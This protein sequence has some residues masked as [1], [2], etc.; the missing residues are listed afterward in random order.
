MTKQSDIIDDP[1]YIPVLD[2]GFAGLVNHLGGDEAITRAARVSYG[3]GTKKVSEERALIRYLMRHQ[4]CYHPDMEVLTVHGWKKWRECSEIETFLVPN[5]QTRTYVRETLKVVS[6]DSSEDLYVFENERMSYKVTANHKMWFKSKYQTEFK[7]IPAN[8]KPNWG[9]FDP[10][11]G[12]READDVH[13][14]G[15]DHFKFIGF[16]LGDGCHAS[17]N[18]ITFHLKKGRKIAYLTQLLQCLEIDYSSVPS[19]THSDGL[20]FNV[21]TPHFLKDWIDTTRRSNE[22]EFPLTRLHQLSVN[23]V[24]GLFDGLV[25]SDGNLA[26]DRAQLRFS[27]QSKKLI[28]LF[29]ALS[30]RIGF[31]A[32]E[33]K[34]QEGGYR[35]TAYTEGRTSLE[36]R[37][38]YHSRESYVGKVY[39]TTTSTGLLAVR[40]GPDKFGFICGNSSPFEMVEFTFHLKMPI[41]VARQHLRHRMSSTNEYSGRY[42][43]M[44]DEFYVPDLEQIAAQSSDNKQGRAGIID[45]LSKTGVQWLIR[46]VHDTAY[47]VYRLLLGE[48][49]VDY[50]D[51]YDDED[52]LLSQEFPG[53]AREIARTVLPVSN[54]TEMYWKIDL[55]NLFKFLRLR[56]DSH[57]QYEIRVLAEAIYQ[58]IQP[59]APLA[60]EAFEDYMRRGVAFSRMDMDVLRRYIDLPALNKDI[61]DLGGEL[62]FGKNY[63]LGKREV[64]DLLAHLRG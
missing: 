33:I 42:S 55:S 41:F 14:D 56:M 53:I 61:D 17:T 59:L 12:Y 38:Q 35:A 64:I 39:C 63:G 36:S 26:C 58:L 10:L 44:S 7:K 51:P 37:A 43:I 27:S 45:H 23:D 30:T 21:V 5:P 3:A 34:P 48:R 9:H 31:D 18:R 2:H 4:H 6:F 16:F 32:H 28:E 11:L 1:N 62:A 20:V 52:P 57:A 24:T 19:S 60:C 8:K 50:C 49:N 54:Y 47:K 40:G 13:G 46:S 25:N 29:C 15:S 22:K